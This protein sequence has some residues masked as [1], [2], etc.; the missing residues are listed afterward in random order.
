MSRSLILKCP[1]SILQPADDNNRTLMGDKQPTMDAEAALWGEHNPN[2]KGPKQYDTSAMV[3][4]ESGI[5]T[6]LGKQTII[7]IS[8]EY[9]TGLFSPQ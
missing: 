4:T 9:R 2:P 5:K 3:T 8:L 6:K 7:V 1:E